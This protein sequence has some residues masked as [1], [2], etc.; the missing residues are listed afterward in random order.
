A[1]EE[2]AV[3]A[4]LA[5]RSDGDA[6]AAEGLWDPPEPTLEVDVGLGRGDD[7]DELA[8]VVVDGGGLPGHGPCARPVATGRG[9]QVQ[10]LVGPLEVVDFA[11]AVEGALRLGEA[12][13][14]LEREDLGLEGA[15][16]AL[17]LAAALRVVGARVDQLDAELEQ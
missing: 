3:A 11:P 12:G 8:L 6:F 9:R 13:E 16:E 5:E 17:V 1:G 4:V 7:A 2:D 15:V 14:A 10:P